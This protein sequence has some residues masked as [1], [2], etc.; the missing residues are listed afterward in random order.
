MDHIRRHL[1][2]K[3]P[4]SEICLPSQSKVKSNVDTNSGPQI[5][6]IQV[7]DS[8]HLGNMKIK[9]IT[10]LITKSALNTN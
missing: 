6:S 10:D 5:C 3:W 2:K 7:Q 1:K 8:P 4:A 9:F